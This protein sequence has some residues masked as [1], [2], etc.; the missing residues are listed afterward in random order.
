MVWE[1][2]CPYRTDNIFAK[3]SLPDLN[4][5]TYLDRFGDVA[6]KKAHVQN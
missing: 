2:A 6:A 1:K 4:K 3:K 5:T